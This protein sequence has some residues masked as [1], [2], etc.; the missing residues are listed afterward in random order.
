[1]TV[2]LKNFIFLMFVLNKKIPLQQKYIKKKNKLVWQEQEKMI[3]VGN[4]KTKTKNQSKKL[5]LI[6]EIIITQ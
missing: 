3:S 6:K 1:M 5:I 2:N 4:S